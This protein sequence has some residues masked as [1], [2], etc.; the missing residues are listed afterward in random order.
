MGRA[1]M[2]AAYVISPEASQ[3][4]A[5]NA[6]FQKR[7]DRI[8]WKGNE[9]HKFLGAEVYMVIKYHGKWYEYSSNPD[10][11]FPPPRE[12]I[13]VDY[14]VRATTPSTFVPAH[15]SRRIIGQPIPVPDAISKISSQSIGVLT[16]G[17]STTGIPST[18]VSTTGISTTGV[19]TTG[20]STTG[21]STTGGSTTGG[22]TT[23]VP[24]TDILATHAL[25]TGVP[26]AAVKN[27][28]AEDTDEES[29]E[30]RVFSRYHD[31]CDVW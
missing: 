12:N 21:V 30:Y 17:V 13:H 1:R 19:S 6:S 24:T 14:G 11:S 22:S 27:T 8:F 23:G 2:K 9:V 31:K 10:I 20:V 29:L 25:T 26:N 18:G 16:T 5:R 15:A 7:K 3:R 4:K 28:Y